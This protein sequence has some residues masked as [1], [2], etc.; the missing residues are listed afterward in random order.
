[1]K[2]FRK[3]LRKFI[4]LL[5]EGIRHSYIRSKL[6]FGTGAPKHIIFKLAETQTELE[7]AFA[8]LHDA[9]VEEG[10]MDPHPSGMR[11]TKYHAL[12]TT[13]VLI[14]KDTRI[15]K[16]VA[17]ISIVRNTALG[18]PLDSVFSLDDIKSSQRHFAE[19]SSLAIRKEY[20]RDP[21]DMLWP[22]LRYF[23]L[24]LRNA[25]RIDAYII[26]VNPSWHDLYTGILGFTK[27]ENFKTT[28]YSFVKNAP[29]AAYFVNVTE[30]RL[31]FYKFYGHLPDPANFDRYVFGHRLDP[32]QH[33]FPQRRYFSV[34]NAVMTKALFEHFFVRKTD[35]LSVMTDI[36]REIVFQYYPAGKEVQLEFAPNH[37][38]DTVS[39][40]Y[41]RFITRFQAKVKVDGGFENDLNISVLD[42]SVNGMR[43]H[44][45]REL[46]EH[47]ELRVALGQFDS[48]YLTAKIRRRDEQIYGLEIVDSD[49]AWKRFI[50][51]MRA[52][53][54]LIEVPLPSVA[55]KHKRGTVRGGRKPA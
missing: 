37:S 16:V 39:R 9:Y 3:L 19:V 5:P 52:E 2:F 35:A 43:V 6:Q 11:V 55:L 40:T 21:Y 25:M 18:L 45:D 30:Q 32:K 26:G 31:K 13:S 1:M 8:V 14:A 51:T 24:Y 15:D 28:Q 34:H 48:A 46:P 29:V 20:R 22:L 12:P 44:A 23:Y 42:Y 36:E 54:E 33:F 27:L 53:F 47:M 38:V 41:K 49:E 7:Q 17:T 50:D 4:S 10:Y